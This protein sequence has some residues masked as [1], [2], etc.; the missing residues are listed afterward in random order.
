MSKWG[1][2]EWSCE[3]RNWMCIDCYRPIHNSYWRMGPIT[4]DVNDWKILCWT[5]AGPFLV[6]KTHNIKVQIGNLTCDFYSQEALM[7]YIQTS[8]YSMTILEN[9]PIVIGKATA[10]KS[11]TD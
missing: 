4:E 9:R 6:R 2:V 7:A 5:C 11:A 3:G 8:L 10:D 1:L